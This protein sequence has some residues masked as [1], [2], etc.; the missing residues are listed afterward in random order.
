MLG[1]I[2]PVELLSNGRLKI[3][4]F[5]GAEIVPD[6]DL[7]TA[8]E[9]GTMPLCNLMPAYVFG[10]VPISGIEY[11]LP[12]M[13]ESIIDIYTL[14]YRY[15]FYDILRR[16][17]GEHNVYYI[18]GSHD[19]GV[20]MFCTK[21]IVEP[22]DFHGVTLRALGGLGQTLE[23][24]GAT[25]TYIPGADLYVALSTGVIDGA[26]YGKP[27]D[28]SDLGLHEVCD[29]LTWPTRF[30]Q[31]HVSSSWPVRKDAWESLPADLQ[32]MLEFTMT[33]G[34]YHP[35]HPIQ[36]GGFLDDMEAIYD[37]SIPAGVELVALSAESKKALAKAGAEVVEEI[38]E[39]D[40]YAAEAA[41][42]I[43]QF[44]EDLHRWD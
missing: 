1:H 37:V 27:H 28:M 6:P 34:Q 29:Y 13:Y 15:G 43:V 35:W 8:V 31:F 39:T 36:G 17:Y 12:G 14:Y 23:K 19:T 33:A 18:G 22:E 30:L 7:L 38:G 5:G 32:Y 9:M 42:A 10:T 16:A 26:L 11:S 21:K 44:M 24:M 25:V 41:A 20:T 4:L 3:E 2:A 40:P